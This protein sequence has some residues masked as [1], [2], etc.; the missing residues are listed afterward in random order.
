MQK[1]WNTTQEVLQM[2]RS[3]RQT[4]RIDFPPAERKA[5]IR[6]FIANAAEAWSHTRRRAARAALSTAAKTCPLRIVFPSALQPC[7][8]ARHVSVRHRLLLKAK[9][10]IIFNLWGVCLL[11]IRRRLA[12][13]AHTQFPLRKSHLCAVMQSAGIWMESDEMRRPKLVREETINTICNHVI[14]ETPLSRWILCVWAL[15]R[16]LE[17]TFG[18]Q[19][20]VWETQRG[21]KI[22]VL[23]RPFSLDVRSNKC[24]Q[25]DQF[26]ILNHKIKGSQKATGH[27][28]T[29]S[30][31][32]AESQSERDSLE[33][34]RTFPGEPPEFRQERADESPMEAVKESRCWSQEPG[35]SVAPTRLSVPRVG[36]V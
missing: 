14:R 23:L 33:G 27:K 21:K 16:C 22:N 24:V 28:Y 25:P 3:G 11:I 26:S 17:S 15:N 12:A 31:R 4:T 34:W 13:I 19:K 10:L 7:F 32:A 1:R 18:T 35:A 29:E 36:P 20:K 30:Y 5:W 9:L 8:R 2:F 6:L